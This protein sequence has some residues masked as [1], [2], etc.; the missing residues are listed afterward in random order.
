[1]DRKFLIQGF[2]FQEHILLG[3]APW[4]ESEDQDEDEGELGIVMHPELMAHMWSGVI[5]TNPETD[6]LSGELIDDFG[7]STLANIELT[8]DR[9][10]F[11]KQYDNRR[12]N[13]FYSF[14]PEKSYWVGKYS[15]ELVGKGVARCI[16]TELPDAFFAFEE[17]TQ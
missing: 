16:L 4:S 13:I 14:T 17:K 10:S 3:V 1:M 9:I 15:G 5:F 6:Q 12:D 7:E 2:F 8:P 11:I